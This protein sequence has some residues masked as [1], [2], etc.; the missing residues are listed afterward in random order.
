MRHFLKKIAHHPLKFLAGLYLRNPR[1]YSSRGLR[2]RIEPSV[3]H[4]GIY[5]STNI[6]ADFSLELAVKNKKVLELGAGSGFIS[7]LLARKGA[8]SFA[9]D[10]NPVALEKLKENAQENQ[11]DVNTIFSDLFS[12]VHPDDYDYII[13]NPPYY[14]KNPK[15]STE[16]AFFCGENFEYFHRL[17][18]ELKEK[19]HRPDTH[20]YMILSE[21]CRL[22]EI[23][24]IARNSDLD[25][26]EVA[27]KKKRAEWNYIFSIQK[28]NQNKE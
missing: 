15:N 16:S 22:D 12:S 11:L 23:L 17:F 8:H 10:I 13:I 2:L 9:S 5:L 24:Q 25:L 4:P 3:F 6:L 1:I 26:S 28:E 19:H 21:D 27:R 14:P 7:L 20:I 18:S